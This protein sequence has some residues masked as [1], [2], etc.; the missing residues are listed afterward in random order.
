METRGLLE[1]VRRLQYNT[2]LEHFGNMS[3]TPE[4]WDHHLHSRLFTPDFSVAAVTDDEEVVGYV[5][6]STYTAGPAGTEERSAHTD[7]IGVRRDRRRQGIAELL[8]KK[9]WLAALQRGLTVASLGTDI[10]NRSNAHL[11]YARL[12]YVAI[13]HQS[14][15]RID[16]VK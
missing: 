13:E 7:Y 5:V 8:L 10:N 15:Y 6:G 11:L 1:Q 16:T 9:V 3:K 2:F 12:G 14:A 4:L